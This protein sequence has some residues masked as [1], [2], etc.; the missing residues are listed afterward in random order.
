MTIASQL[1]LIIGQTLWYFLPALTAN[2]APVFASRFNWLSALSGP[3]DRGVHLAGQPLLGPNKTIRGLIIGLIFG[4]ITGLIQYWLQTAMPQLLLITLPT[5]AH[6]FGWGALLGFGALLGDAGKSFLKRRW[7]IPPGQSWPPWDQIDIVV[8]VLFVTWW[9]A[10]P[11]WLHLMTAF[12][13][14][15]CGMFVTSYF[16]KKFYIK[17]AL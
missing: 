15:G 3:L 2:M 7:H 6:A 17:K 10:P 12:I 1:L 8:G 13:I 9:F 5:A 4:S 16:G 11:A 14:I